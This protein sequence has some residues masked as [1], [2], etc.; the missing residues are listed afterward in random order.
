MKKWGIDTNVV[1]RL[2]INDDKAQRQAAL[3][4]GE[5]LG[6]KYYGFLTII[7]LVELD[8][9]LRSQYGYA[10]G[11][12]ANAIQ[13]ILRVRGLEIENHEIVVQALRV[14][15]DGNADFADAL[16]AALSLQQ[17]CQATVTFDRKAA[18]TVSG[19]ELLG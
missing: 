2:I 9:A 4:F 1:L 6:T 13:K 8:W 16:I 18:K 12:V 17:G 19:M 10:K 14:V 7:S 11:D 15:E 5:G 3:S